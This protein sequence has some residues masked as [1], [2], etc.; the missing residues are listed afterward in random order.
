MLLCEYTLVLVLVSEV[1][2]ASSHLILAPMVRNVD[3]HPDGLV[4]SK[5]IT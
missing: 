4:G 5:D 3:G 2:H 1:A